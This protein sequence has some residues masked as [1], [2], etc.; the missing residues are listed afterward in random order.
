MVYTYGKYSL[1]LEETI[2]I[3]LHAETCVNRALK[4]YLNYMMATCC[5]N[6][7]LISEEFVHFPVLWVQM[8]IHIYFAILLISQPNFEIL[9]RLQFSLT[10]KLSIFK[11]IYICL[12][13]IEA[14]IRWSKVSR[15][16]G[17]KSMLSGDKEWR[18]HRVI[19]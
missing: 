12:R 14:E 19:N 4:E 2:F 17:R 18:L 10:C 5:S 11:N 1:V 3:S 9:P 13:C 8:I 7:N 15:P 16:Q 6:S